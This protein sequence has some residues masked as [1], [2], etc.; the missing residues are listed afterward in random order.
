MS[1]ESIDFA[2]I[3]ANIEAKIAALQ[4]IAVSVRN[5]MS[6]GALAGDLPAGTT[7]SVGVFGSAP[8]L[9]NGEIP[10][11]AFLGK[12]IPDA[13]K[14]YLQIMRRKATGAEI[15]EALQKGGIETTSKDFPQMVLSGLY[16]AV[17]PTNAEILKIGRSHWALKEWYPAGVRSNATQEKRHVRKKARKRK[18]TSKTSAPAL[19]AGTSL[20]NAPAVQGTVSERALAYLHSKKHDEYSLEAIAAHVGI[21]VKG[22]RMM[23]GK[24]RKAGKVRMSAP[25]TYTVVPFQLTN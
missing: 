5:A 22:A 15:A 21:G 13:A 24:L 11:G 6:M 17:K 1:T 10:A 18:V 8:S 25:D 20:A 7:S 12:S 23:L 9:H 2:A 19:T 14:L 16:R 3:L 4:A